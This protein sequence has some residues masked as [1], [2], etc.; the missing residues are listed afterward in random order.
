MDWHPRPVS[1]KQA[2]ETDPIRVAVVAGRVRAVPGVGVERFLDLQ[3][4]G[5]RRFFFRQR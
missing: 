5:R 4:D 1:E 3:F 2:K